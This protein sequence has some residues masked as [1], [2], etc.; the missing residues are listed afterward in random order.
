[1]EVVG[2]IR[3]VITLTLSFSTFFWQDGKKRREV[4]KH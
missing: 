2:S 4:G 3:G 1:V